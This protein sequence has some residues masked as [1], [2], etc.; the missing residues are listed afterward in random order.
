M[1][2][3]TLDREAILIRRFNSRVR[4]EIRRRHVNQA[5]VAYYVG[6]TQPMFSE[7]LN[8][9]AHWTLQQALGICEFLEIPEEEMFK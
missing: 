3:T 2:R 5:K 6:I 1:A 9:K 7:R 4:S 8:E